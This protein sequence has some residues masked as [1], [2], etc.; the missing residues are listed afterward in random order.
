MSQYNHCTSPYVD[1]D[2]KA[3][4]N[5]NGLKIEVAELKSK[6][7]DLLMLRGK[8]EQKTH[9]HVELVLPVPKD[10]K[11]NDGDGVNRGNDGGGEEKKKIFRNKLIRNYVF[12]NMYSIY[13]NYYTTY[14]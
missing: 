13:L 14:Y 3:V 12:H 5:N 8:V 6:K 7:V 10:G 4:R 9:R 1:A 2:A 11:G